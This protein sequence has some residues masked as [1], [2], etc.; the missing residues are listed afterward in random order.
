MNSSL[1]IPEV[2]IPGA[3]GPNYVFVAD[4][5]Q[6]RILCSNLNNPKTLLQQETLEADLYQAYLNSP[7]AAV[8]RFRNLKE[9]LMDAMLKERS[10]TDGYL[11]RFRDDNGY[12]RFGHLEC[13]TLYGGVEA[14]QEYLCG[15]ISLVQNPATFTQNDR[16]ILSRLVWVTDS[17]LKLTQVG[18]ECRT[19]GF[20]T[21]T[22]LSSGDL[23]F[24]TEET[25]SFLQSICETQ[26]L[27]SQPET[28]VVRQ[29]V[30][31]LD[32]NSLSATIQFSM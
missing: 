7:V 3:H 6:Q 32:G 19:L 12:W 17:N 13:I 10:G 2:H 11:F 27:G 14:E 18:H 28:R 30:R 9:D 31:S 16:S 22:L 25:G 21:A 5:L 20:D 29:P 15:V 26:L 4:Q 8:V 1:I 24:L 23:G